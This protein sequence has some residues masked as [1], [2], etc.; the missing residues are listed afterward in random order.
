MVSPVLECPS[1]LLQAAAEGTGQQGQVTRNGGML[2]VLAGS[3]Q[4]VLWLPQVSSTLPWRRGLGA[5]L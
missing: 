4:A 3:E 2:G 1:V 5:T